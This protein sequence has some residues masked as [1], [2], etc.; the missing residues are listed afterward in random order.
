MSHNITILFIF[1]T[2][3]NVKN[4]SLLAVSIGAGNYQDFPIPDV[5]DEQRRK[6]GLGCGGRKDT[7]ARGS[8]MCAGSREHEVLEEMQS[9]LV[10]FDRECGMI[11]GD[12]KAQVMTLWDILMI[13]DFILRSRR[14]H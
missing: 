12:S 9:M 10:Q 3:K 5:D 2:I 13:L 1:L 4:H 7:P 14:R 6:I 11:R 8:S